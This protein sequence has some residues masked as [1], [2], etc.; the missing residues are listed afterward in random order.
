MTHFKYNRKKEWKCIFSSK[1]SHCLKV[2]HY[3][4]SKQHG[5]CYNEKK[6]DKNKLSCVNEKKGYVTMEFFSRSSSRCLSM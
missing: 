3:A 1:H 6:T 4:L 5:D 2:L